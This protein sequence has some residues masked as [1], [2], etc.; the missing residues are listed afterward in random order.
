M[1]LKR[2]AYKAKDNYFMHS[3]KVCYQTTF[4][5]SQIQLH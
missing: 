2:D 3:A 1:L 5:F 4:L